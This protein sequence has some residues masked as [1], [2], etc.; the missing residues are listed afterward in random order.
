MLRLLFCLACALIL[1]ASSV[2]SSAI[3]EHSFH[4]KNL[5]VRR[6][7]SEQ[8]VTTVNG[9]LPGPTIS[10]Q[11]GDTLVV[12]VFN[13][14]P[15]N[16]TLHWHGVF[17]LLSAWADGAGMITQC[18]ISPGEKRKED[19]VVAGEEKLTVEKSS[20]WRRKGDSRGG[21]EKKKKM[22]RGEREKRSGHSYPFPKPNGEVPI[23]LGEWWNA[24]VVVVETQ[25]LATG[26]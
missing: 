20:R 14:S 5:T 6:L 22:Q 24:N 15:Y 13:E 18:P 11:E 26:A 1:L 10:V 7:C 17:Q 16:M 12:H 19:V 2:A 21:G 25:A 8:V 23:L 9:S 4:V 3:V